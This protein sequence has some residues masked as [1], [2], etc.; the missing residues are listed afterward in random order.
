M[1]GAEGDWCAVFN[2]SF[3]PLGPQKR[4]LKGIFVETDPQ[5]QEGT[6][7]HVTG[8]II[9]PSGMRFEVKEGYEAGSSIHLHS[10]PQ[11][12][13]V[14]R[15]DMQSRRIETVLRA[16]PTPTKQVLK[17][18][19]KGPESGYHDYIWTKKNGDPYG[20]GEQRRPIMK[21][22][23]WTHQLAIPTLIN[24]GILQTTPS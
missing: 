2:P 11:I 13:W 3:D 12:G 4:Y 23:E 9:T 22:N 20:P 5:T 19:G 21:C 6:M 16:L 7:L 10:F 15:A 24:A 17:F 14:P 1:S 18:W 8:D